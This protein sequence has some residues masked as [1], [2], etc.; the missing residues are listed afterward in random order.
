MPSSMTHTYF[1]RDVYEKLSFNCQNKI[2]DSLE[3]YK[4]FCQGTDPFMFYHFFIGKKAKEISNIQDRAHKT[5]TRDFFLTIIKYIYKNKLA[6]NS[7]VMS[8]LYGYITHYFLDLYTHPYIYYKTGIFKKNDNNTYKYNGKHQELEYAIDLYFIEKR[9]PVCASKFKVYKKM[10]SVNNLTETLKN[11][12]NETFMEV[13]SF[14]LVS[15][16]YNKSIWYMKN[17]FRFAN[18]DPLGIKLNIY[19]LIDKITPSNVVKLRE[20]SFYNKYFDIDSK[21]NLDNE[22]WYCPWDKSMSYNSSFMDLYNVALNKAIK[23]IE[24]VTEMFDKNILDIRRLNILFRDL[25]FCTGDKC[26]KKVDFKYFSY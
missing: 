8:Y 21:L 19:K 1:G 24:E 5:K 6:D 7:E 13:Y 26:S 9:E 22:I 25:S 3:Y 23:T 14:S 17:F 10:F 16:I 15:N 20:L 11:I 12:I 4:L 18:Y 2:K